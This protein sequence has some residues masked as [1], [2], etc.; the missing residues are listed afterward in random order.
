MEK[1]T[2][3]ISLSPRLAVKPKIKKIS[4]NSRQYS[5]QRQNLIRS[6]RDEIQ[7]YSSLVNW[8]LPWNSFE[9]TSNQL[10]NSILIAPTYEILMVRENA[11]VE[12]FSSMTNWNIFYI[13]Y[14]FRLESLE[15]SFWIY[16]VTKKAYLRMFWIEKNTR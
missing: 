3:K 2:K 11:K 7:Y 5:N 12:R 15:K 16:T 10:L 8:V 1:V 13:F 4:Y 9:T 14:H 6:S